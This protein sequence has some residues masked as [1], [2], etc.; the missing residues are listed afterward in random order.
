MNCMTRHASRRR[1]WRVMSSEA[2]RVDQPDGWV[3]CGISCGRRSII[4]VLIHFCDSNR[5]LV[6]YII[7]MNTSCTTIYRCLFAGDLLHILEFVW[8]IAH[9]TAHRPCSRGPKLLLPSCRTPMMAGPKQVPLDLNHSLQLAK[10]PKHMFAT[11]FS[12]PRLWRN[13][14]K[15]RINPSVKPG[16]HSL[17]PLS[18]T[19]FP[20]LEFSFIEPSA[21]R[22]T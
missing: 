14:Q 1:P 8:Y 10:R 3:I 21:I 4:F 2:M 20:L 18:L 13:S 15:N 6:W 5:I 11:R 9:Q 17:P 16:L 7:W 12:H 19:V 22:Q